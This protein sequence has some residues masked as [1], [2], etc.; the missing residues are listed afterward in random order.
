MSSN[1]C[2]KGRSEYSLIQ[3]HHDWNHVFLSFWT[4]LDVI[5]KLNHYFYTI[6]SMTGRPYVAFKCFRN[7]HNHVKVTEMLFWVSSDRFEFILPHG[8]SRTWVYKR[9][10]E[11]TWRRHWNEN[12][13]WTPPGDRVWKSI[14]HSWAGQTTD[15]HKCTLCYFLLSKDYSVQFSAQFKCPFCGHNTFLLDVLNLHINPKYFINIKNNCAASHITQT[16]DIKS[17]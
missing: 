13:S 10:K 16:T 14:Y 6:E 11:N 15:F 8:G 2:F 9:N 5:M 1:L 4:I 17:L 3:K 12:I 7:I